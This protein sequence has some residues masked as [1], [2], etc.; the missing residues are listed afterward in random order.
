M[1]YK[2]LI[3][4][5]DDL[6]SSHSANQ[7][8]CEVAQR[9]IVKNVSVMAC[10]PYLEEA[11]ELLAGNR[12]ITFGMHSVINSEWD[13][14]VWGP[15]A[16]KEQVASLIDG[17]GV[18]YQDV[19]ELAAAKPNL[20]E[21]I[22]E[23]KYQLER[24]RKVGF[25]ISYIDS[26]MMPEGDIPGLA[27]KFD[28][29][30]EEEGLINHRYY[31]RMLPEGGKFSHDRVLFEKTIRKMEGQYKLVLHPAKTSDEMKMTGNHNYSG[32]FIAWERE[33]DYEFYNDPA[34]LTFLQEQGVKLL[35]Y[36]DAEP[37]KEPYNFS[38]WAK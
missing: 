12:D 15:V 32:E 38:L 17:R 37:A 14:V 30:V 25:E 31:N 24:L 11:A 4:R 23:Y 34:V 27:E 3:T 26:H 5:A 35:S 19:L 36:K 20:D 18:F 9:G 7:A 22:T 6:A 1:A 10:G 33:D 16:P 8:I 29:W 2:A 13:R 28:R 21:I